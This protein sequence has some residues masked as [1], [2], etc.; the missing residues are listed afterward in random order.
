MQDR[1]TIPPA[2]SEAEEIFIL[3]EERITLL[4]NFVKLSG[5]MLQARQAELWLS[6]SKTCQLLNFRSYQAPRTGR[7]RGTQPLSPARLRG[8][9]FYN[10]PDNSEPA[11]NSTTEISFKLFEELP[12]NQVHN[13][14]KSLSYALVVGQQPFAFF[15]AYAREDGRSYGEREQTMLELAVQQLLAAM[16]LAPSNGDNSSSQ[17]PGEEYLQLQLPSEVERARRHSFNLSLMALA[18]NIAPDDFLPVVNDPEAEKVYVQEVLRHA[19]RAFRRNLRSFDLVCQHNSGTEFSIILPHTSEIESYYVARKLIRQLENDVSLSP[20]T[21]KAISLSIGISTYPVLAN[22]APLLVKQSWQALAQARKL[23]HR[24]YSIYIWGSSRSFDLS[25]L[26]EFKSDE[27]VARSMLRGF[28]FVGLGPETPL[29][30]HAIPWEISRKYR[31]VAV[32]ERQSVLTVA[33]AD[34]DNSALIAL[35]ARTTGRSIVPMVARQ[36]ELNAVLENMARQF[37]Q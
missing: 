31:C 26:E 25:K 7:E 11:L 29:L 24:N 4:E 17:L 37:G 3:S 21:R 10:S 19:A 2:F 34:P 35:L 36:S 18:L 22:S 15:R 33:M 30:V 6:D 16:Q 14:G 8:I 1:L 28:Q 12:A 5:M 23:K 32:G 27:M 20:A 9:D 13:T